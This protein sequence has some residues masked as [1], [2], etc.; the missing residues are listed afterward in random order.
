MDDITIIYA[1]DERAPKHFTDNILAELKK[2]I[3]DLPVVSITKT[4]LDFGTNIVQT[5]PSSLNTY[6]RYLLKAAQTATTPYVAFCENDTLYPDEHFRYRPALDTFAYNFNRWNIYTWSKPPFYS[7]KQRKILATLIAP[8]ELFVE[9]IQER[10]NKYP[11]GI[12]EQ[13]IGEPGR[14]QHEKGLGITQRKSEEF[15]TYNPIVVFSHPSANAHKTSTKKAGKIRALSIP[16]WGEANKIMEMY[17]E[18]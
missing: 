15:L 11:D 7:L 4:L 12:P 14:N 8:R 6:Y 17:H 18:V 5:E 16:Y 9:V 1:N 13:W 3:G 2:S 10:F